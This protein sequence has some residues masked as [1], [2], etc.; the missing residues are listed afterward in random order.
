M[1]IYVGLQCGTAY[2]AKL[3]FLGYLGFLIEISIGYR[4]L[5][6]FTKQLRTEW[7]H[8]VTICPWRLS[9]GSTDSLGDA[10]KPLRLR[11]F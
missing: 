10:L 5:D 3:V 6:G 7:C 9:C 4:G 1:G 8:I 2:F 11:F